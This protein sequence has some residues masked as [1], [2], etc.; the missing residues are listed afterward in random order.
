[1]RDAVRIMQQLTDVALL[2]AAEALRR[3]VP[4]SR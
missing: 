1:M 4:G 3:L 2:H